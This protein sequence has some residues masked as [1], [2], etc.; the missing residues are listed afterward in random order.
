METEELTTCSKMERVIRDV[1]FNTVIILEAK[2]EYKL[3]GILLE[4]YTE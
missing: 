4:Y 2:V 1:R 3:S